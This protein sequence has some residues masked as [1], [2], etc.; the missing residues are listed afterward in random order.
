MNPTPREADRRELP[1][2]PPAG[3]RWLYALPE[4]R[5]P[6]S[7]TIAGQPCRLERTFKH[8]FFAAT[9]LYAG[10]RGRAVVKF[11]R[12]G[13]LI[14]GLIGRVLTRRESRLYQLAAGVPGVPEYWGR[15]LPTGFAHAFVPG[16]PLQR[17]DA[18]PDDFFPRLAE[19]LAALHAR[20]IAYVDLEKRE[21]ILLGDDGQPWL[22]DF[23]ISWHCPPRGIGWL[24][25]AQWLLRRLQSADRYHLAK[26]WR[27]LNAP[28][29]RAALADAAPPVWIRLHRLLFRPITLARRQVLVWLGVRSSTQVR[30]EEEQAAA[31][32]RASELKTCP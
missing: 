7:V 4:R 11:G 18:L 8:D 26:H 2:A 5:L 24:P 23:Q 28:Q 9:G 31:R 14:G 25:P 22:F 1:A 30:G 20:H 10:P 27:R 15:V 21:N 17:G 3:P 29:A 13:R 19:L 16:R 6:E 12:S 32:S